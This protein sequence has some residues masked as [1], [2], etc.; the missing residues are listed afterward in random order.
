MKTK[1]SEKGQVVIPKEARDRLGLSK[2]SVL[3]V[4]VEGKRIILESLGGPPKDLFVKAGSKVTDR[5]LDEAKSGSD[6]ARRLLMDLG[7]PVE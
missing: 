7:V 3:K 2:G 1:V 4:W 5:I 6:K